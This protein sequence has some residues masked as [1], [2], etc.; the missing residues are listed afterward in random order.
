MNDTSVNT[1]RI[2]TYYCNNKVHVSPIALRLGRSNADRDNIHY[3]GI[4]VGVDLDGKLK[5]T[6]FSEYGD[7]FNEHPD[8]HIKFEKYVVGG[9]GAF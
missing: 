2:I 5:P 8:T 4:C 7:T 3:G 6:A 1:F 9:G